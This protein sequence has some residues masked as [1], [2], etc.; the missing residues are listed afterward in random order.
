[1]QAVDWA[2]VGVYGLILLAIS[3]SASRQQNSTDEYFRGSRQLPWWAIGF[4]IIAT[5]FSAASLLG[6][7]G[8]G[9]NNGLLYLQLQFG[10]LLG[11]LLVI[12]L[13]LPFFV[14]LNLTTA[15]EYLERRF[16]GKTRSLGSLCFLLFVIARLGGLLYA[17]SLAVATVIGL[18]LP[19]AILLVGIVS[20]VYTVAGGIAAVVWTDVLQFAMIFVG[21]GAGIW[22]A[23]QGVSGGLG[24]LWST[25]G[26]A[27]KLTVINTT[28]EPESIRSLPTALF[29]YG[30]L[31]FA[32]AGTNQ[33]SV[34]RYVSCATIADGRKAILLG[35][36]S[37]FMG[38]AATLILGTLLFGFYTA[39]PG[40]PEDI[41]AD[42]I[43]PYF[44][45]NN[46]LP[47]TS[48]LLVAAILAA[49][50]SSIDSALHSLATCM[51]VDFYQRYSAHEATERRSLKVAQG[52][53]V[54]WGVIGIA[55]AFYVASTGEALL[56]F[57][58]KYTAM[59]LGPLLGLFLMGVLIPRVNANGA[60][61]GT[62]GAVILLAIGT[63]SG[64]FSFPGIWQSA[65]IAPI[66]V[67]LGVII[68]LLGKVPAQR[69]TKGLTF[70][71]KSVE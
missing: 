53:I 10:D 56:P 34:Q 54:V 66:G 36:F 64:L 37:G 33:Q 39:N 35:W 25:A 58:I 49:A 69:S 13:F 26:E 40:L 28:W 12:F 55:S 38:V 22:A 23:S 61:Y 46:G 14:G 11:Y 70:W 21:L 31:A 63:T 3:I 68:S 57:L 17:A 2:I 4:S 5:S 51:T 18:P 6:G 48:G 43:L 41:P 32:V 67:L 7:P 59:F 30:T 65:V 44:I 15:Y 16:D 50:M 19:L 45:V 60:F 8:E 52:L 9:Y 24:E 20:I 42:G 62:I 71:S 29:A 47:G 1:M 27:G